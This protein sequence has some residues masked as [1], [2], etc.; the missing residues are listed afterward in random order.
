RFWLV[1]GTYPK[2]QKQEAQPNGCAFKISLK[3]RIANQTLI[4]CKFKSLILSY[5]YD[6]PLDKKFST[7]NTQVP[8]AGPGAPTPL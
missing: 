6:L 1:W 3:F 5:L 7:G 4:S 2:P 8:K